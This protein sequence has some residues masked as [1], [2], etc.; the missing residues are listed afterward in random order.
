[1][2]NVALNGRGNVPARIINFRAALV[3]AVCVTVAVLAA[4]LTLSSPALG[5][6]LFLAVLALISILCLTKYS[7]KRCPFEFAALIIA[8]V[9]SAVSFRV[10]TLTVNAWHDETL[11]DGERH[12]ISGIVDDVERYGDGACRVVIGAVIA[13]N[14][15]GG[16][17]GKIAVNIYDGVSE[18]TEYAAPGDVLTFTSRVE[19][20]PLYNKDENKMNAYAFRSKIRHTVTLKKGETVVFTPRAATGLKGFSEKLKAAL[21]ANMGPDYGATAFGMLTG[22]KSA[23]GDEIRDYY[24]AAGLGHLLAVSGLHVGFFAAL[25][26]VIMKK[27]RLHRVAAFFITAVFLGLYAAIAEFSPSVMRAAA[28]CLIGLL[29]RILGYNRDAPSVL[30]FAYCAVLIPLPVY[31][32]EIG[33]LMS[34]GAVFGIILFSR[35]VKNFLCRSEFMN[36]RFT[37][38]IAESA[39]VIVSAQIGVLPAMTAAIGEFQPYSLLTNLLVMPL[40]SLA[41]SAVLLCS[42]FAVAFPKAGVV[43]T[44]GGVGIVVVD[45]IAENIA[46]LPY[47]VL[48]AGTGWIAFLC[49]PLY[50]T[51]SRFVML[52]GKTAVIK[53]FLSLACVGAFVTCVLL[54]NAPPA[55]GVIIAVSGYGGVTSVVESGGGWYVVGD[56]EDYR[57]VSRALRRNN[58]TV[59]DAVYASRTDGRAA[60]SIARLAARFKIRRIYSPDTETIG[61]LTA[62]PDAVRGAFRLFGEGDTLPGGFFGVYAD[63]KFAAYKMSFTADGAENS[64]LFFSYKARTPPDSALFDG[65]ALI[66]SATY[67][68]PVNDRIY[69]SNFFIHDEALR[70]KNF[71]M[72]G[73][74]PYII[75]NFATG[76][77]FF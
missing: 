61:G 4:R 7:P 48:I 36:R 5:L 19:A 13:D 54:Q 20:Y 14:K 27:M 74:Y 22:G 73:G 58:V 1:M 55:S 70:P 37:R 59:I 17:R 47:S 26:A 6:T 11:T 9:L 75:F 64:A 71:I 67:L 72:P 21:I 41:F 2:Q 60:K 40:I 35:P 18:L 52:R 31:L 51:V 25:V 30:A 39:A 8:G 63:G 66:R 28:M 12:F 44:V 34:V 24:S 3:T 62:L 77:Y 45:F 57:N 76:E 50:F 69:L 15:R 43:L 16:T 38:P 65:A 10:F 29:A 46:K 49:Y 32:F 23:I 42:L 53:P 68:E 56:L 33:F